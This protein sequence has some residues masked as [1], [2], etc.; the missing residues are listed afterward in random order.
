MKKSMNKIIVKDELEATYNEIIDYMNK[1]IEQRGV[2]LET[3]TNS[4]FASIRGT[5]EKF[6]EQ[7][8]LHHEVFKEVD[9]LMNKPRH[10]L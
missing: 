10:L 5:F 4:H 6:E 9:I 3:S 7:M 8:A 1:K 2:S